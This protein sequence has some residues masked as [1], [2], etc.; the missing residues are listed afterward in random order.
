MK[1]KQINE[2]KRP[3][4]CFALVTKLL[5]RFWDLKRWERFPWLYTNEAS[6]Q[7]SNGSQAGR[8]SLTRGL[9]GVSFKDVKGFKGLKRI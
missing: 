3:L 9:L 1:F 6:L 7:S 2:I 8:S 5:R 4:R